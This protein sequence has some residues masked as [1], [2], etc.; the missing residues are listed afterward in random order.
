MTWVKPGCENY[1]LLVK[2]SYEDSHITEINYKEMGDILKEYFTVEKVKV[3]VS[4]KN[5]L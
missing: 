2:D 5:L 3:V 1:H 4:A